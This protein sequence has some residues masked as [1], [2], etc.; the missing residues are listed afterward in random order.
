MTADDN[1]NATRRG[2]E[3]SPLEL[4]FDIVFA[5][6]ISQLSQH[7]SANMSWR[8]GLETMVLLLA[9]QTVWSFT[10][11]A[12]TMVS[13]TRPKT[14]SM[15]LVVM[16]L[17]L[18]MNAALPGAFVATPWAFAIPL[19]LIQLG[20]TAWT[21]A[22]APDELYREHYF[23]VLWWFVATTPLWI[24]GAWVAPSRAGTSHGGP[25]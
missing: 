11:W 15:L 20:R 4:L 1:T 25:K 10:S 8:G 14:R 5:F 6:A 9:I 3:V 12:A 2:E 19:L 17:G 16:L 18:F 13:N 23:R 24:I 21:I 22:T 7:L